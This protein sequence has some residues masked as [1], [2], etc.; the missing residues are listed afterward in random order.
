MEPALRA[1]AAEQGVVDRVHFLGW[2][3]DHSKLP[4]ALSA[5][6]GYVFPSLAEANGIVVQEAM[7]LGLPVICLNWGGPGLLVTPECGVLVE[8]ACEDHVVQA[9]ADAM[10]RLALDGE[11][12]ERMSLTGRARALSEGYAWRDC[13]RG[14]I[15]AYWQALETHQKRALGVEQ[16]RRRTVK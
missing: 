15:D 1:L 5:Y 14:W 13:I 16:T 3:E 12:A 8:P 11:L 4:E 7:L 2:I 6:R 9:L 10:D